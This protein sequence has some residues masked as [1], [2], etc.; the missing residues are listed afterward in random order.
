M[1]RRAAG[2]EGS[3]AG[4]CW[5]NQDRGADN[6]LKGSGSGSRQVAREPGREGGGKLVW[7][8]D[9]P[10]A[11]PTVPGTGREEGSVLLSC[12][13]GQHESHILQHSSRPVGALQSAPSHQT[14][15]NIT[16]RPESR[17]PLVQNSFTLEL[18]KNRSEVHGKELT[19]SRENLSRKGNHGAAEK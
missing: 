12:W 11:G 3:A 16:L 1:V 18:K 6:K 9:G 13:T 19:F 2:R 8:R 5:K 10:G 7:G 4:T 14:Y 15:L 17:S